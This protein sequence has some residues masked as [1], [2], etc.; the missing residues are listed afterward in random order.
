MES[1]SLFPETTPAPATRKPRTKR[2]AAE[3]LAIIAE[4]LRGDNIDTVQRRHG[5]GHSTLKQWMQ[6]FGITPVDGTQA[7]LLAS[8]AKDNARLTDKVV[9][10]E[11]DIRRLKAE[12]ARL[13]GRI[14]SARAALVLAQPALPNDIPWPDP[15]DVTD[16]EAA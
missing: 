8:L 3:K 7:R 6:S 16:S 10:L 15:E 9:T 1:A 13:L 2:S 12:N 14:R 5:L 11:G 4:H